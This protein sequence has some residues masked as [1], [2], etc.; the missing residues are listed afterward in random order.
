MKSGKPLDF[1]DVLLFGTKMLCDDMV[2]KQKS[3]AKLSLVIG[4]CVAIFVSVLAAIFMLVCALV[5]F[6]LEFSIHIPPQACMSDTDILQ[7]EDHMDN[8]LNYKSKRYGLGSW[9]CDGDGMCFLDYQLY[10]SLLYTLC[11]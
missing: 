5:I 7:Q 2:S 3:I 9:N 4:L 8:M 10:L 1:T 6:H 11:G